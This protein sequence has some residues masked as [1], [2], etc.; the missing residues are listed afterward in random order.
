[1]DVDAMKPVSATRPGLEVVIVGAGIAG[2]T[3]ALMLCRLA[4]RVTLVERTAQP[5]EVGAGIMLQPNG[6]A[7]LDGLGLRVAITEHG[8]QATTMEIYNHRSRLIGRGTMPDFG[9]G[10][11]HYTAVLRSDLH[12]EL[13]QAVQAEPAITTRFG[14]RATGADRDGTLWTDGPGEELLTADLIVGADGVNSVIRASGDFAAEVSDRQTTY[15][16]GLVPRADSE[17]FAEY[18]T[19]LGAFGAAPVGRLTYFYAAGYRQPAAAALKRRDLAAFSDVWRK[20]LSV[21]G[22]VLDQVREIDQLLVNGVRRVRCRRWSDGKLVLIGD[23]A[24]A[25]AP[26][27]GQGANSAMVDAAVLAEELTKQSTIE[28]ALTRYETRRLH[29]VTSLQGIADDLAQLSGLAAGWRIT[30]R[31][32]LIRQSIRL[33]RLMES[34]IRRCQQEAPLALRDAVQRLIVA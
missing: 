19:P 17:V 18:W 5:A 16:R 33:P 10:L 30:I 26:N 34:Q 13:L 8:R 7:V 31:D 3:A 11:D 14:V 9:G 1:M 12:G 20:Q 32:T 22:E 6:L 24:H 23:A 27:L 28:Q 15:V 2:L 25:M 4:N 29:K 21:A